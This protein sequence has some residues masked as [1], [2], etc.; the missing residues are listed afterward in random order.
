MC[1][2]VY[3]THKQTELPA[4]CFFQRT[5]FA[6][7]T[8]FKDI[9]LFRNHEKKSVRFD[10]YFRTVLHLRLDLLTVTYAIKTNSI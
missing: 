2:C 8:V 7:G 1:V 4:V 9:F 6:V 10:V 3:V 5:V